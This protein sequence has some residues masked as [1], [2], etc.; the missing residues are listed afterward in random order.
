MGLRGA[1]NS[2]LIDL[3]VQQL[4]FDLRTFQDPVPLLIQADRVVESLEAAEFA[5]GD[6]Q[7]FPDVDFDPKAYATA[8][9]ESAVELRECLDHLAD[10]QRAADTALVDKRGPHQSVRRPLPAGRPYL[11][12]LL[13]HGRQDRASRSG[14]AV[15][16]PRWPHRGAAGRRAGGRR[17]GGRRA[18]ERRPGAGRSRDRR[19]G[20]RLS[21]HGRRRVG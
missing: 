20:H 3:P 14:A 21:G 4:G 18:G 6:A 5:V 17:P 1:C 19:S 10:L 9:R 2:L 12:E 7:L 11:R 13:P 16:S 8:V 15:D